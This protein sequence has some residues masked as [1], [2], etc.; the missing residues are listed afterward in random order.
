MKT[1]VVVQNELPVYRDF[2][3]EGLR[4]YFKLY[5]C[6]IS[7]NKIILPN[8][9]IVDLKN[10]KIKEKIDLI[11]LNAGTREFF[12]IIKYKYKFKPKKIIG[13]TQFV[14]ANKNPINKYLRN[15]YLLFLFDK[16]LLYYEHEKYLLPLAI[17]KE[18]FHGL[19]NTIDD[20]IGN[21]EENKNNSKEF[22]YIGRFTEKSRLTHLLEV[23][24]KLTNARLNV[25]GV[26]CDEVPIKYRIENIKYH[27][28]INENT[29][30]EEISSACTYFVYPGDVG[31]SIV[32]AVKLGLIPIVH[33]DLDSHMPEC[34]AVA[35]N[36][37]ILYFN[38]DDYNGLYFLIKLL[39]YT[40]FTNGK[41]EI[42]IKAAEVFSAQKMIKNFQEGINNI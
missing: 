6:N 42:K 9:E 25:I 40:E 30:I 8:Q 31:L 24:C 5:L 7:R 34:R 38:K 33:S 29:K 28:E 22:F 1:L 26:K 35:N 39:N 2:L 4:Q 18:K 13:W 21:N 14:G 19:N 12:K 16:I 41:E 17:G 20:G 27:G 36:F 37:P 32:H 15:I 3:W 11:V 23:F 10:F